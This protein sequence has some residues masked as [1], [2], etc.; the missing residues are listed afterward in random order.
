MPLPSQPGTPPQLLCYHRTP[1]LGMTIFKQ[2]HPLKGK[3]IQGVQG[4]GGVPPIDQIRKLVSD[5][6]P[7]PILV[8]Q[9]QDTET[10]MVTHK[11]RILK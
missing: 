4:A 7:Y 9:K 3:K 10:E 8:L 1:I 6:S 11:I 5:G 2:D